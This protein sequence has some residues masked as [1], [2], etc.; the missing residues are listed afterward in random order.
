MQR[1]PSLKEG[2][3]RPVLSSA[4]PMAPAAPKW[5]LLGPAWPCRDTTQSLLVLGEFPVFPL[6]DR[7][8]RQWVFLALCP[9]LNRHRVQE[10]CVGLL[11][12]KEG[13]GCS[14]QKLLTRSR[15]PRPLTGPIFPSYIQ[16]CPLPCPESTYWILALLESL[17]LPCSAE[18]G[19]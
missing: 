15:R 9:C 11:C 5:E 8:P 7:S 3:S 17:Q 2:T 10:D 18:A 13:S 12:S 14:K 19:Y 4:V 16:F 6:G 1:I